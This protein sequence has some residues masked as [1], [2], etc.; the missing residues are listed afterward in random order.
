MDD[1]IY[2]AYGANTNI[3]GM[4]RR[5]PGAVL[6]G[7]GFLTDY[8]LVFRGVADVVPCREGREVPG[9]LWKLTPECEQ[10]LD[11]FEGYPRLYGKREGVMVEGPHG[12]TPAMIYHM[13]EGHS[14]NPP[15]GY[16]LD[17]IRDGYREAGHDQRP[18]FRAVMEA[19]QAKE[20]RDDRVS[21]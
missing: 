5:C 13:T 11:M 7:P 8:R 6:I 10:S 9:L 18:L 12:D 20:R 21:A 17:S 1:R 14:V 2:F 4:A 3:E 19:S 16:Y 15:S